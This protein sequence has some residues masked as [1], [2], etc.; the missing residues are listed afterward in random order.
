MTHVFGKA[1]GWSKKQLNEIYPQEAVVIMKFL[2]SDNKEKMIAERI[3]YY[4]SCIDKV[5][6]QYAD[7]PKH[8]WQSFRQSIENLQNRKI[9]ELQEYNEANDLPDVQTIGALK[10][11]VATHKRR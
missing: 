1:Y 7:N 4:L 8:V 6:I 9:S 2:A 3:R 11:F 5:D 10:Q